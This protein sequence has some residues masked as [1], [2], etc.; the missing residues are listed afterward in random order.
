MRT[1]ILQAILVKK[2]VLN[3]IKNTNSKTICAH[4]RIQYIRMYAYGKYGIKTYNMNT[5]ISAIV[6]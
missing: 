3:T 5:R 6:R 1:S 2:E 4:M